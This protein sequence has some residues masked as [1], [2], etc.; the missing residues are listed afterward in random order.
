MLHKFAITAVTIIAALSLHAQDICNIKG[1]ILDDSLKNSPTRIEKVYLTRIDEYNRFINI[2][3]TKVKKGKY[4]FKYKMQKEEPVMLY[5]ITG[6]DNGNIE[7]FVEPGEINIKTRRASYPS[8]SIVSG[9]PTNEIYSQYKKISKKCTDEQIYTIKK[10]EQQRG[11]EWMNSEEGFNY[12]NRIGA[13][14]LM[15]CNAE[16]INF[17]LDNNASPMAPLMMELEI[18]DQLSNIY[19]NQ[20]VKSLSPTLHN[21]PYYRSFRNSV[22]AR[23]LKVGFELPDISLPLLD[24]TK[25][26]LS[27]YRG[28]YVL[29]DFWASWCGPCRKAIPTL[30]KLYDETREHKENFTI[31]SFSLDNKAKAWSDIISTQDMNR[32]GW[33]HS[34]DLLGWNSP[35]A[36]SMGVK[37]IPTMILIDPDGKAILFTQDSEE[38]VRRIKQILSG[39]LYYL[40]KEEE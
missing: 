10:L 34:C 4:H 32:E 11:E 31:I 24:G 18:A 14:S 3:S 21:H 29:L 23:E 30:K 9:T 16:R 7:F 8:T 6:F 13:L 36:R 2:D 33:I 26:Y 39:D 22:L 20:L 40:Q 15:R 28:K 5:L 25:T 38:V 27:D 17:L 12:R 37:S 35:S 19:A 1:E